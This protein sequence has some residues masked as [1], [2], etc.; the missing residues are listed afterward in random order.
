M[1]DSDS[2]NAATGSSYEYSDNESSYD[3]EADGSSEEI[4]SSYLHNHQLLGG[5]AHTDTNS[6]KQEDALLSSVHVVSTIQQPQERKGRKN[7][8]NGEILLQS[9]SSTMTE[10]APL[11]VDHQNGSFESFDYIA[12]PKKEKDAGKKKLKGI[13]TDKNKARQSYNDSI[14]LDNSDLEKSGWMSPFASGGSKKRNKKFKEI[15]SGQIPLPLEDNPAEIPVERLEKEGKDKSTLKKKSK[16]TA[17]KMSSRDI[18]KKKTQ[19]NPTMTKKTQ[20]KKKVTKSSTGETSIVSSRGSSGSSFKTKSSI[21]EDLSTL[22]GSLREDLMVQNLDATDGIVLGSPG[23]NKNLP[24]LNVSP[25]STPLQQH[26]N[27][28]NSIASSQ[29]MIDSGRIGDLY[30]RHSDDNDSLDGNGAVQISG[31]STSVN[32]ELTGTTD[33]HSVSS[34]KSSDTKSK[35]KTKKLDKTKTL[36]K[37]DK[38]K[39]LVKRSLPNENSHAL[40]QGKDEKIRALEQALEQKDVVIENLRMQQHLSSTDVVSIHGMF[41][42]SSGDEI[43]DLDTARLLIQQLRSQLAESQTAIKDIRRE[44]AVLEAILSVREKV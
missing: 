7:D 19:T 28:N 30:S 25:S 42:N 3:N 36:K 41:D 1:S 10:K 40:I 18:K 33:A 39:G 23:R 24:P 6:R 35:A 8:P 12:S 13:K 34:K 26:L 44:K 32:S 9:L 29:Q 22:S 21:T 15:K 5:S 38:K 17:S 20:T 37:K 2:T 14:P 16:K 31:D 11:F 43:T 27:S 4:P